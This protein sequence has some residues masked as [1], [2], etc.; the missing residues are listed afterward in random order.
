MIPR[1]GGNRF[2]GDAKV[3][4]RPGS[5]QSSNLTDRHR[6]K[7][8]TAGNAIDRIADYTASL[9]GPIMKDK[10]WFFA[11]TR[12]FS[13][14]NFIANT[15]MDDG[16][17]GIDDQFILNGMARLTWQATP[18][19]KF[20][21]YFDEIHKY[22]GHD[23]Q[24]NYDPETAAQVWNSPVYHT[25]AIK[26]TSPVSSSTFLEAGFSNNTEYYTNEYRPGIEKERGSAEWYANAAKNEL[27]LGGYTRA[28]PINTTE[29]PVAF[30][31]NVAA[32]YVKGNHT[33]KVGSSGTAPAG[34]ETGATPQASATGS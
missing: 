12:Y 21:G 9:G 14:N 11:S 16:S 5:W 30:Y 24:A 3:A 8:L 22:R 26:W 19:N 15:F 33:F 32:T 4:M 7:N 17:Q 31:W 6:A 20:S 29:S 18:R 13:V 10:L 25:T 34:S 1:E 23:M 2:S 27:D 28:A